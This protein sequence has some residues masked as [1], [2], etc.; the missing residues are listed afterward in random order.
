[1][2]VIFQSKYFG[3]A[4]TFVKLIL[5][6]F[7]DFQDL[8]YYMHCKIILLPELKNAVVIEQ[9]LNMRSS[10]SYSKVISLPDLENDGEI[11]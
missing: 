4:F 5:S 1:M 9:D 10:A 8:H 2:H 3:R 6:H 7:H 11:F